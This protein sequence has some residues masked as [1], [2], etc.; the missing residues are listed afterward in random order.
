MESFVVRANSSVNSV[1]KLF[2]LTYGF[3]PNFELQ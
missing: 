1:V 3:N 2:A